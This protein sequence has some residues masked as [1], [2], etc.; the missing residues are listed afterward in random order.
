MARTGAIIN[1]KKP[2]FLDPQEMKHILNKCEEAG[3]ERL[4]LC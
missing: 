4:I 3:N 1:I 2:Q